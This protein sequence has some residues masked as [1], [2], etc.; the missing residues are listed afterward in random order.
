[1]DRLWILPAPSV[2][3]DTRIRE[4]IPFLDRA[5]SLPPVYLLTGGEG[6]LAGCVRTENLLRFFQFGAE[7]DIAAGD[8]AEGSPHCPG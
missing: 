1:M 3:R 5:G 7:M 8:L 4:L 6:R 2:G